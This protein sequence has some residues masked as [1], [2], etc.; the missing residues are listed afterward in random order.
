[1]YSGNIK[2]NMLLLFCLLSHS[3]AFIIR[4]LLEQLNT[5]KGIISSRAIAESI[6]SQLNSQIINE[7]MIL[8]EIT[9]VKFH[10]VTDL[11]YITVFG[12]SVLA[13]YQLFRAKTEKWMDI[14]TYTNVKKITN[15]IIFIILIIFTKGVE[16]AI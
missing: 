5:A 12:I 8:Y 4:G 13:Q 6:S 7:N 2:Y 15:N 9:N 11:F 3:D 14:E 16:N 1:M 10:P